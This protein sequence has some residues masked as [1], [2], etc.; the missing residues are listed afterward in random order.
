[1]TLN[2]GTPESGVTDRGT[3]SAPVAPGVKPT[4]RKCRNC[5]NFV[6]VSESEYLKLCTCNG[7]CMMGKLIGDLSLY[8]EGDSGDCIAYTLSDK[9][10]FI[11]SQEA[12][13]NNEYRK[14][15]S[16]CRDG[17][18]HF[19]KTI[20]KPLYELIDKDSRL[21]YEQFTFIMENEKDIIK[22]Y[23][24]GIHRKEL[25]ELYKETKISKQEYLKFMADL[26]L[27]LKLKWKP[28]FDAK[29]T[30]PNRGGNM[31]ITTTFQGGL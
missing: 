19:N 29:E 22:K 14:F 28:I 10:E 13:F 20:S 18:S 4:V 24:V 21:K 25:Y 8:Y 3:Q 12:K 16:K 27:S 30:A 9:N 6:R 17:R 7:F 31:K 1:M 15:R 23:F 11:R 26:M 5:E 2:H